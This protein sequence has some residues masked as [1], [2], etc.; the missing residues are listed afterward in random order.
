[1]K[2]QRIFSPFSRENQLMSTP[3]PCFRLNCNRLAKQVRY[4]RWKYLLVWECSKARTVYNPG[5]F[6]HSQ[7][8][9]HHLTLS[10]PGRAYFAHYITRYLPPWI[11][12][13]FFDPA[14]YQ[15][16]LLV[17]IH[18]LNLK[19]LLFIGYLLP[20]T[21]LLDRGSDATSE[22][23]LIHFA[24]AWWRGGRGRHRKLNGR[25]ARGE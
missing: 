19:Q 4:N 21:G 16:L 9:S 5:L 23:I 14:T 12:R 1:M 10:L 24:T 7:I 2:S 11:F 18:S 6:E 17:G 22:N 8:L 3:I 15:K 25:G 20:A 13:L